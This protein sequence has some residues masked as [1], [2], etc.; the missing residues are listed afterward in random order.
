MEDGDL[1]TW[2]QPRIL[3]VLE[4]TLAHVTGSMQR[5]GIRKHWTPNDPED[6][7]WGLVMLKTIQRYAF[8]SV[9]VEVITFISGEV[10]DHAADWLMKYSVDVVSVE[11]FNLEAFQRSLVWRR[12]GI[13]RVIDTD[14][15]RLQHYGQLGHQVLFNG[16]F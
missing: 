6:W 16:E 3:L 4:D 5:H 8:N 7:Q 11:Y 15:E 1:A 14:R 2:E 12:N 13:Q 10:R 9:P